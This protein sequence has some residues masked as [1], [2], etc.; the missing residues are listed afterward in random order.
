MNKNAHYTNQIPRIRTWEI[1]KPLKHLP[2]YN[3]SL[4]TEF[5]FKKIVT[6]SRNNYTG[7]ITVLLDHHC[8]PVPPLTNS[9]PDWN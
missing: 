4:P 2:A 7:L 6:W 3:Y 9:L 1:F 8:V 5:I